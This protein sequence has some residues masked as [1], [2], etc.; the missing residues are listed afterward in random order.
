MDNWPGGQMSGGTV[1]LGGQY[2]WAFLRVFFGPFFLGLNGG[3]LGGPWAFLRLS[4]CLFS[5]FPSLYATERLFRS[6]WGRISPE[7]DS[8]YCQ[9]AYPKSEDP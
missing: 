1:V 2:F 8:W 5:N 7:I 3:P 9:L 4:L 6:N